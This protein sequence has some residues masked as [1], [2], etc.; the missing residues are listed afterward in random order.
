M[1]KI[2]TI[3]VASLA[4]AAVADSYS[5]QIGV[6]TL[7]LSKKNNIIPV[8]F[9]SLASSGDVTADAL[10]CTNNIPQNSYLLA[11]ADDKYSAWVLGDSGWT[12]AD[13][14]NVDGVSVT[15]NAASSEL[16]AG[17]AIWLS[18][19]NA[20]ANRLVSVYGKV[21]ASTNITIAAG[22]SNL[23]CNPKG[24]A[25]DLN[26][27]TGFA[28][29]NGDKITI[30]GTDEFSGYYVYSST[31]NGWKRVTSD[32]ISADTVSSISIPV[33]CGCWYV[34]KA[35]SEGTVGTIQW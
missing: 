14:S 2:L 27:S 11:Y 35:T 26:F 6:T 18:F 20:S 21:A 16:S 17:S 15:G 30:V 12:A 5:P 22:K 3:A 32:G 28:F 9:T 4:I 8:Q 33:N 19:P 23:I 13:I 7:S 25:A 34:S 31:A 24:A 10:V 1:K 29:T